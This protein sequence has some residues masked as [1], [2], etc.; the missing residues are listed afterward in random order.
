M[1]FLSVLYLRSKV[2][3]MVNKQVQAI[4]EMDC[5]CK[6]LKDSN[7]CKDKNRLYPMQLLWVRVR[8]SLGDA[9]YMMVKNIGSN[10]IAPTNAKN[11]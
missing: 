7:R 9:H 2:R 11:R 6:S 3:Q 8:I 1:V 10:P 5:I 4:G